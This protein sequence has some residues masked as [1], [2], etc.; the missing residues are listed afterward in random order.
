M[1]TKNRL[2]PYPVLGNYDSVFPLLEDDAVVMPDPIM[3]E[4]QFIFHIEL[5]Q[6]NQDISKL[7]EDN[8]AEYLCEIYCKN[9]F[10]RKKNHF[11][12]TSF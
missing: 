2:L 3:D 10:L 12:Q 4:N 9:T 8:K 5:N 7:I 6:K 11:K 1:N